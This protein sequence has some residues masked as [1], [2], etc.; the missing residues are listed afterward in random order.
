V[1]PYDVAGWTLPYQFGVRA[2]AVDR[3]LGAVATAPVTAAAAAA[4]AAHCAPGRGRGAAYDAANTGCYAAALAAAARGGRAELAAGPRRLALRA[5][6][7]V[8]LYKPWTANM[9]EGWTRWVL[10]QYA[11]PYTNVSDA[12]VRAG[13]L[14]GFDVL[15]VPD[16]PVAQM[17]RGMSARQVPAEYAGGLG[18]SGVTA[19]RRFVEGGGRLVLLDRASGFAAQGLGLAVGLTPAGGRGGEE[20]GGGDPPVRGARAEC[21]AGRGLRGGSP[22]GR[23]GPPRGRR[24]SVRAGLDPARARRPDAPRRH[25]YAR[26]GRRVLHQLDDARRR[27]RARGARDRALPGTRGGTS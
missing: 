5:A 22:A 9:D 8:A 2:D 4:P 17:R 26:H 27:A 10:E 11:L 12:D 16:M 19:V 7:R 6:P 13:K 1:P 14:A 23:R 20:G 25:G 24:T 3:P 18:D 21:A 15:V